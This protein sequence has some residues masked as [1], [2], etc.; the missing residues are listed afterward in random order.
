MQHIT[1]AFVTI[2]V[3]W[4]AW[5]NFKRLGRLRA[6]D[7][8]LDDAERQRLQHAY[9]MRIILCLL[10]LAILPFLFTILTKSS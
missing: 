1:L 10:T 3:V 6:A 4:V 8:M 7:M 2:G 5:T 9:M